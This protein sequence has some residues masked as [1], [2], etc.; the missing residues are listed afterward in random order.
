M[1]SLYT[2][3]CFCCFL[4]TFLLLYPLFW[5]LIQRK[6]WHFYTNW[7][8]KMW[9]RAFFFLTGIGVETEWRFQPNSKQNYI[10][11]ANHASF[12]DIALM[13][14]TVP[15][16]SVFVGKSSVMRVP[17]FGYKF[18][19]LHIPVDRSEAQSRVMTYE[20]M[21][22]VLTE[23]KNLLIYPEGGIFSE[24]PPHMIPFKIGAFRAAIETQTPLVPVTIINAWKVLPDKTPIRFQRHTCKLVFHPPIDTQDMSLEQAEAMKDS[25][26][27]TI[28]ACIKQHL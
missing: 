24:N 4:T 8:Y 27:Q 1:R 23:G 2:V 14:T 21:K 5:I 11:A 9:G 10:Y 16:F 28:D 18:K 12:L 25:V 22:K 13:I 3:W 26:F 7:V 19:K 15:N 20:R 17:L 6:S